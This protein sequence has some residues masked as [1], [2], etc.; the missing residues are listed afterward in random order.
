MLV[1]EGHSGN[2]M[3]VLEGHSV[4]SLQNKKPPVLSSAKPRMDKTFGVRIRDR[5]LI[6]HF[7]LFD[8]A[9]SASRTRN[10]VSMKL[11]LLADE[12]LSS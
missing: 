9:T 4:E 11:L 5:K 2:F 8:C 1:L 12:Q 10:D 3:L 7:L 6:L